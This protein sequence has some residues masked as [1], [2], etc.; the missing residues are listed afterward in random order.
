MLNLVNLEELK[1]AMLKSLK[2]LFSANFFIQI[3]KKWNSTFKLYHYTRSLHYS[4][5]FIPK[6]GVWHLWDQSVFKL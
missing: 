2:K 6:S 1:S 5:K 3:N 4:A